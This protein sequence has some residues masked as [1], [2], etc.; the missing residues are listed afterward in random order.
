M[1]GKV[2]DN[3]RRINI[4]SIETDSAKHNT[5]KINFGKYCSAIGRLI[6]LDSLSTH[7]KTYRLDQLLEG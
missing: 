4:Q 7:L 3:I 2:D 1:I 6:T 5:N